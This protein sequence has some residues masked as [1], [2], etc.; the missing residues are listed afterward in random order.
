MKILIV[1]IETSPHLSYHFGRWNQNIPRKHTKKESRIICWAAKWYD[2]K[3]VHFASVWGTDREDM[4]SKLW[5]LMDAAD[6]VVGFN[7]KKFDVK[8][9]NSE[10]LRQGWARPSPYDQVDLIQQVRKNFSFSSNRL[11][12]V[13]TELGMENKQSNKGMDLWIEVMEGVKKSRAEMRSYN[14]QD[15][16]VTEELYTRIRGWI[17]NHPNWGLF[18][19]DDDPICPTCGSKHVIQHKKRRTRTRAYVQYQC[20]DCGGYARGRKSLKSGEGVLT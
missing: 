15:V 1:D 4:L 16:A 17:D 7:S 10:F 5:S 12:D 9:I 13:L 20:Q 18:V 6:V 2:K 14:I 8:R 19:N 11:D 3:R